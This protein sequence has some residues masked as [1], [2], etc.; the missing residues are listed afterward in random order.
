MNRLL[1]TL[2]SLLGTK[3]FCEIKRGQATFQER[4]ID[5]FGRYEE[6]LKRERDEKKNF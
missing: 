4:G 6:S 3:N 1:I 2:I 5:I